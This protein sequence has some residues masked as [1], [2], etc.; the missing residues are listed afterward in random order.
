MHIFHFILLPISCETNMKWC[1]KSHLKKFRTKSDCLLKNVISFWISDQE[2]NRGTTSQRG[3]VTKLQRR[4]ICCTE[5]TNNFKRWH[6]FELFDI[7]VRH[8]VLRQKTKFYAINGFK[9]LKRNHKV[10][11]W[12]IWWT[13]RIFE[14]WLSRWSTPCNRNLMMKIRIVSFYVFLEDE[15]LYINLKW[16]QK[17]WFCF[18]EIRFFSCNV[19]KKSYYPK[20]MVSKKKYTTVF[21]LLNE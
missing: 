5:M 17:F 4:P 13:D 14:K 9:C 7:L 15:I 11:V 3:Q 18:N 10:P 1:F 8:E 6:I 19:Q 21:L 20:I 16:I 12:A 2:F